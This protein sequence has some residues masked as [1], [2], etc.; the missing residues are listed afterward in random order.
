MEMT[1]TSSDLWIPSVD[2]TQA[3]RAI[4]RISSRAIGRRMSGDRAQRRA[5]SG[6]VS[7][8][9]TDANCLT[10]SIHITSVT[11]VPAL[12]QTSSIARVGSHRALNSSGLSRSS[13]RRLQAACLGVIAM[14]AA[15]A[16]A[17]AVQGAPSLPVLPFDNSSN[18]TPHT[19]AQSVT[20]NAGQ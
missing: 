15:K 11:V 17:R 4:G 9:W 7:T 13:T 18:M 2:W 1:V 8:T 19:M 10:S 20:L 12:G 16:G 3:Y 14:T 5:S 6:E